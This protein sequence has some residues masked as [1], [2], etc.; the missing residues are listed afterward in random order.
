VIETD[1]GPCIQTYSGK[2]F[3]LLDPKPLDVDLETIAHA[4]SL[5]CRYG[6][7]VRHFYSVAEHCVL[8]SHVV[9]E[10]HALAALLHDAAEAYVVDVPTPLKR[11]LIGYASI[12]ANVLRAI[13]GRY[14]VVLDPLPPAVKDVDLR[15][16]LDERRALMGPPA[17]PWAMDSRGLEPLGVHVR[18]LKPRFAEGLYLDRFM[19]LTR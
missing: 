11:L 17:S 7:H 14:G 15:I 5:L 10:E 6:G 16:V 13:G 8:M 1:R 18:G 3:Y 4:L 12:E 19:E 2:D 9:P